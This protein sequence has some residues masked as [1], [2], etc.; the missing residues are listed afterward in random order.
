MENL[1]K[2]RKVNR[3]KISINRDK[4]R[5]VVITAMDLNSLLYAR[6]EEEIWVCYAT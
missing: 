2:I 4:W 6:E 5:N 1:W 3:A